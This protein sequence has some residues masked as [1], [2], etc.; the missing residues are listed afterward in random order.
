MGATDELA[1]R[2]TKKPSLQQEDNGNRLVIHCE[3][4]ASPEP[5]IKWFKDSSPLNENS[6]VKAS[7]EAKDNFF[8]IYLDIDNVTSDDSGAYKVTAKNK[9]GEV[10][11]SI[12]L[13]FAG[14]L[15]KK[16]KQ[17]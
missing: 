10:S 14:K 11:A 6:R 7:I 2:I 15:K 5:E 1:P 9:S 16:K 13:N 17:N 3:I 4:Q 8:N 12:S